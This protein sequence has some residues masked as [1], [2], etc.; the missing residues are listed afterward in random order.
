MW[1][2]SYMEQQIALKPRNLRI[3][4]GYSKKTCLYSL[5]SLTWAKKLCFF[6]R[7]NRL[8]QHF[9]SQLLQ[10]NNSL[11]LVLTTSGH[12][13]IFNP[14]L[15]WFC[16]LMPTPS[17][18]QYTDFVL[19]SVSGSYTVRLQRGGCTSASGI[20]VLKLSGSSFLYNLFNCAVLTIGI[21]RC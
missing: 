6:C 13:C 12:L 7:K 2:H 14:H 20:S 3:L 16:S 11:S 1:Y 4:V 5:N 17:L 21:Y 9:L 10:E 19:F 18:C 8:Q 15:W